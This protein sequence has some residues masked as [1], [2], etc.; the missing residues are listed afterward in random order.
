MNERD[1]ILAKVRSTTA[2]TGVG[3]VIVGGALA[4]W[5][6]HATTTGSTSDSTGTSTSDD[7][8]TSTSDGTDD[9]GLT[10]PDTAPESGGSDD[11]P[12]ITSGGS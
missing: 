11:Q 12:G 2:V 9:G 6:G 10:S 3:A 5:L 1:R 8:G 4:G 7:S